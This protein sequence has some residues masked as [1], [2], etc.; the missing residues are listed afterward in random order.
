MEL[1]PIKIVSGL[2]A[3]EFRNDYMKKSIP[4]VLKDFV[5]SDSA[6]W[7]KWSYEYFK[8]LTGEAMVNV[9]GRENESMDRAASAPVDKMTFGSYLDLIKKE[10]TTLRL[11][12]FNLMKLKPELLEDIEYNDLTG[13]KVIRWL[14]L[15]FFGGE[16]SCTRNHFDIDMSHVFISQFQGIKRIWLFPND[17]SDLLYKLPFNFHGIVNV[18]YDDSK[19]YPALNYIKGFEAVIHPGETLF[20]PA[21][22]YHYIQYE[23]EGYSISVRALGNWKQKLI[24][25]RNIV[26]YKNIDDLMRTI[27]KKKWFDMKSRRAI[28]TANRVVRKLSKTN[29]ETS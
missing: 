15:M 23:T 13:G 6:C 9:Y 19:E 21:G 2:T 29:S 1:K 5:K 27:F 11:F 26:V 12:L 20:M 14:P 17:M 3:E 8:E 28:K 10:P 22:W 4:V 25:F 18:K 16:G 24:G 7:S